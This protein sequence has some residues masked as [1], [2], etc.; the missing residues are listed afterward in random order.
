VWGKLVIILF[1]DK[2]RQDRIRNDN[3]RARDWVAP[4]VEK[5]VESRLSWF[6]HV[7]RKHLD[8]VVRRL[9]QVEGS[10]TQITRTT[11]RPTTLK[12]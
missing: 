8:F 7:E 6:G 11:G 1:D 2:T 9:D 4:I 3:I 10:Q 5:M 12:P